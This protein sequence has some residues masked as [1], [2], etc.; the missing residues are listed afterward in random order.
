MQVAGVKPDVERTGPFV[1]GGYTW[2]ISF[3]PGEGTNV[4]GF[5]ALPSTIPTIGVHEASITGTGARI[6]V[7]TRDAHEAAAEKHLVSLAAP[8]PPRTAEVQVVACY[9]TGMTPSEAASAGVSFTMAL[10][11]ETTGVSATS[12]DV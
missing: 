9:L 8:V 4:D 5:A 12:I 10:R 11:G 3:D 2:S 6:R 1:G 7:K